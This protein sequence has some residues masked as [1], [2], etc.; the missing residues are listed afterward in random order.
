M[1]SFGLYLGC[2]SFA[3]L[4]S[5][6]FCLPELDIFPLIVYVAVNAAEL[7]F[8]SQILGKLGC[9][10]GIQ[11]SPDKRA[12]TG[13]VKYWNELIRLCDKIRS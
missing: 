5:T 10:F 13:K 3:I 8:F 7:V 6:S 11:S 4:R 1:Q 2:C 12:V 9:F